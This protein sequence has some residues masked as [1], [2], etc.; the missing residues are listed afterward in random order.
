[1]ESDREWGHF[2]D[3]TGHKKSRGFNCKICNIRDSRPTQRDS[4]DRQPSSAI[5]NK[6]NLPVEIHQANRRMRLIW[7]WKCTFCLYFVTNDNNLSA[8]VLKL[9]DTYTALICLWVNN[10]SGISQ[11]YELRKHVSELV[12]LAS[13]WKLFWNTISKWKML[14][15]QMIMSLTPLPKMLVLLRTLLMLGCKTKS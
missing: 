15:K 4:Q 7:M 1:M 8:Q 14:V 3:V 12:L 6:N 2:R 10:G 13:W 5:I 11:W 9:I